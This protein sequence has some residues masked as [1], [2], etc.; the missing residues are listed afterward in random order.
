MRYPIDYAI[1]WDHINFIASEAVRFARMSVAELM[2]NNP[3]SD[4]LCTLPSVG[5]DRGPVV[6]GFRASRRV[7]DLCMLYLERNSNRDDYDSHIVVKE[8]EKCLSDGVLFAGRSV[9]DDDLSL[10]LYNL[11]SVLDAKR[12]CLIHHIPCVTV[13]ETRPS[14]FSIGPVVFTLTTQFMS[15]KTE[16]IED[17]EASYVEKVNSAR[18]EAG[19][20]PMPSTTNG[21]SPSPYVREFRQF[22]SRFPWTASV[23]IDA[24]HPKVSETR[25]TIT[26]QAAIDLLCVAT[27]GDRG[28]RMRMGYS[29]AAPHRS[30]RLSETADGK[31]F[32]SHRSNL[33]GAVFGDGWHDALMTNWKWFYSIGGHALGYLPR[34]SVLPPIWRRYFDA[35]RWYGEGIRDGHPP[36]QIV[37]FAACLER[38]VLT[39]HRN[40]ITK[41]MS[42]RIGTLLGRNDPGYPQDAIRRDVER[43]YQIRGEIMHGSDI[44]KRD[45][46]EWARSRGD[47]ICTESLIRGLDLFASLSQQNAFTDAELGGA[48]N[49]LRRGPLK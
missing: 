16:A 35:L 43:L 29:A 41:K 21:G 14:Q 33:E 13:A 25:A 15:E 28:Q 22:F 31:L 47:Y 18:A 11:S 9:N 42:S 32:F 39:G 20:E 17:S 46:L 38:L 8:M 36:G 23:P 1:A 40:A 19:L 24:C 5:K 44:P 30:A 3:P 48:F 6:V 34:G 37:K 12:V 2:A 26:V 45:D 4:L 27:R 7:Y 10:L 49:A